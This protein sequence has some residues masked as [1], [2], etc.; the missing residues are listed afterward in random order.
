MYEIDLYGDGR[1]TTIFSYEEVRAIFPS[2]VE[3]CR[4]TNTLTRNVLTDAGKYPHDKATI[5]L[6]PL[7]SR[8]LLGATDRS[9]A[10]R[11]FTATLR[12]LEL[13][14]R[15]ATNVVIL[16]DKELGHPYCIMD[17]NPIYDLRTASTVAVGVE[18]I[19]ASRDTVACILGAGPVAKATAL[20]LGA[21]QH[22]PREIRMTAR[23]KRSFK[24][25][26]E[27]L[28][29]FFESLDPVLRNKTSLVACDT[30][31]D[32]FRN[33][34]TIIDAI[35]LRGPTTLID[36]KTLPSEIM[37]RITYVDVGKQ[38]LADSLVSEFSSYIFDSLDIG[39]RLNSPASKA[40][41]EGRCNL[42]AKKCDITQLL[43]REIDSEELLR[44]RLL[45]VMGVA[46]I[47]AKI[48]EDG[49]ERLK[50]PTMT[51]G[52]LR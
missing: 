15:Y 14:R 32:A 3:I 47:D 39:Y 10:S 22:P 44:P 45:T 26:K 42:L 37:K 16:W 7:R 46:S 34:D 8:A 33:S 24:S 35:S 9:V 13:N 4:R 21:L 30:L 29:A 38:A 6:G 25:V 12:N 48:A 17:G 51:H 52:S 19:D 2:T 5:E 49:F 50:S 23:R 40:L 20:A 18:S 43:N 31:D 28:N 11:T 41:R 36:K 27:R 1:L